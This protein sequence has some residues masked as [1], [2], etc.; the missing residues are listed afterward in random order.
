MVAVAADVVED[1]EGVVDT[2]VVEG[3]VEAAVAAVGEDG[4]SSLLT[5]TFVRSCIDFSYLVL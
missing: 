1:V 2:V 4:R 5:R 3:T